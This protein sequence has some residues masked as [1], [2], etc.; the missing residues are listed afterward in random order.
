MY[1]TEEL[2][3]YCN[4]GSGEQGNMEN[5]NRKECVNNEHSETTNLLPDVVQ[6][7]VNRCRWR[8]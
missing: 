7:V 6:V 1:K 4:A 2:T 5:L 8:T 3:T